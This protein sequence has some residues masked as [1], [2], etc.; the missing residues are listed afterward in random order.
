MSLLHRIQSY[1]EEYVPREL[2]KN[3]E[4]YVRSYLDESMPRRPAINAGGVLLTSA[5]GVLLLGAMLGATAMYFFDPAMGRRRRALVRDQALTARDTID[6][7][8]RDMMSRARGLRQRV[9]LAAQ[10]GGEPEDA[11]G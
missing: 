3:V 11:I 4:S 1:A 8:S 2:Q 7:R 5:G 6:A 9:G 10:P